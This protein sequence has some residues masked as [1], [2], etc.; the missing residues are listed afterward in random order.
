MEEKMAKK[1][2]KIEEKLTALGY[3]TDGTKIDA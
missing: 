1:Q 3:Y 2:S